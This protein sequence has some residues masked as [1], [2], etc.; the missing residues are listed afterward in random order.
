MRLTA[1]QK[2]RERARTARVLESL[3][4]SSYPGAPVEVV[5]ENG[6]P[7]MTS[8][9]RY[10]KKNRVVAVLWVCKHPGCK[11]RFEVDPRKKR[12]IA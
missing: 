8:I 6:H 10:D 11:A 7:E 1:A 3:E 9:S 5:C 4:V 12:K 2:R